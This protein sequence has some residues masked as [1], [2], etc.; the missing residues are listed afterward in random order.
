MS[1]E[2]LVFDLPC[3]V[4]PHNGGEGIFL[5]EGMKCPFFEEE[6]CALDVLC[7]GWDGAMGDEGGAD[8]LQRDNAPPGPFSTLL[9]GDE[10]VARSL[11]DVEEAFSEARITLPCS[12]MPAFCYGPGWTMRGPHKTR[13]GILKAV[14]VGLDISPMGEVLI[15][16]S[17]CALS[18]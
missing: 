14:R 5:P 16:S 2:P 6:G 3:A 15:Y 1:N 9:A 11:D 12:V 13:E 17:W 10:I 18:G 7:G 4:C 8:S